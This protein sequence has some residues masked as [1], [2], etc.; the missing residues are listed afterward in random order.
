MNSLNGAV[1]SCER[2]ERKYRRYN[3]KCPVLMTFQSG[4]STAAVEGV[5]KNVSIGGLLVRSSSMIPQYAPV[6]FTIHV[7]G[8]QTGRPIQ[9]GGEG[10]VVRVESRAADGTYWIAVQCRTAIIHLEEYLPQA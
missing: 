5:S 1:H 2:Q 4:G 9:L 10:H 3:L 7:V 6:T 8:E